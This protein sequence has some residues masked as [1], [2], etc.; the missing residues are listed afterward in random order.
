MAARVRAP[1]LATPLARWL[2]AAALALVA[3][4]VG[5]CL[6][7]IAHTTG[8]TVFLFSTVSPLLTGLATAIVAGVMVW[9]FRRSHSLFQIERLPADAVVFREGDHGDCAYFIRH[10]RVVVLDGVT[11]R[12][13]AR[14]GPGE[15]FGEMAL[16]D[17]RPRNATV[18]TLTPVELMVLGKENFLNMMHLLP[19]TEETIQRTADRRAVQR[20]EPPAG[21][22]TT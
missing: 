6:L 8:G 12:Q 3:V 14:L 9:E 17:D 10:G 22:A 20:Q 11:G 7:F 19:A 5:L 21:R 4:A 1:L 15:H 18:R 13:L 2:T 16:I